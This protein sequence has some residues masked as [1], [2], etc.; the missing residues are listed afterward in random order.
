MLLSAACV[1]PLLF[2]F[3]SLNMLVYGIIFLTVTNKC[4]AHWEIRAQS[5]L[6]ERALPKV[7]N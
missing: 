5:G 2:N 3:Q 6:H 7:R 4:Q 1:I